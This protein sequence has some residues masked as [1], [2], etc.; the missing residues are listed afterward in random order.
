MDKS[1]NS[2]VNE[3]PEDAKD[4][5]DDEDNWLSSLVCVNISIKMLK[6]KFK[7]ILRFY[8]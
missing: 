4:F 5:F 2:E 6:Q 8:F 1:I 7:S 3:I